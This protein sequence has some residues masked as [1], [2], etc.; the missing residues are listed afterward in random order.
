MMTAEIDINVSACFIRQN[1]G[2]NV[3]FWEMYDA[4]EIGTG[5]SRIRTGSSINWQVSN[6]LRLSVEYSDLRIA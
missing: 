1:C 2:S 6:S 4:K 5:L 3:A